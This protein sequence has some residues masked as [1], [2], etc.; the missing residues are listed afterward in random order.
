MRAAV[1]IIGAGM[2]LAANH[3]QVPP[4]PPPAVAT[5]VSSTGTPVGRAT[6]TETA[7]GL[8]ITADLHDLPPGQHG[9]HIHTTGR[10]DGPDFASAGGHWNPTG[11]H[12]GLN[13]PAGPHM[14]DLPNLVVGADGRGTISGLIAGGTLAG[15][16]DADGAAIV[17]HAAADDEMTD[18][19]GNSGARIACGTLAAG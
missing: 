11:K 3:K 1:A 7:Q 4:A 16:L 14:G 18:P 6:V 5:L 2:A 10:C 12:H 13:N 9:I 19:S 8:R 17:V 15:L